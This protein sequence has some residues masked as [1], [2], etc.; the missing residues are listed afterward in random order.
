MF[1]LKIFILISLQCEVPHL[2]DCKRALVQVHNEYSLVLFEFNLPLLFPA[3]LVTFYF[4][5]SRSLLLRPKVTVNS[6]AWSSADDDDVVAFTF[7][8]ER[9]V[10]A[11][12]AMGVLTEGVFI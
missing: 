4:L 11:F 9:V 2:L 6:N 8:A 12:E 10:G 3:S 1:V 7:D 5:R